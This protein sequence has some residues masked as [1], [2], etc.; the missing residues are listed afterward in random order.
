[1]ID[2][3]FNWA[4]VYLWRY[5][6]ARREG[7]RK[8]WSPAFMSW[9]RENPDR[10]MYCAYTHWANRVK[11]LKMKLGPHACVEGNSPFGPGNNPADEFL[12]EHSRGRDPQ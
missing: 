3:I 2:T 4:A 8:L 6:I 1:M 10:C 5:R 12:K 7:S 9:K 11:G